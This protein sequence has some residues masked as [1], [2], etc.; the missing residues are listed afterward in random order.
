MHPLLSCPLPGRLALILAVA[1][2]LPLHPDVGAA[3]TA[4][5]PAAQTKAPPKPAAPQAKP[6]ARAPQAK[7]PAKP[8]APAVAA[9]P[10]PPAPPTP[11]DLRYKTTYTTGGLKTESVTFMK[12]ERERFEFADMVLIKQRDQKRTLQI[13]RAANTYLVVPDGA[14]AVAVPNVPA[15]DNAPAKAAGVVMVTTTVMDTGERKQAFGREAR[16][17]KTTMDKQPMVGACDQTKQHMETD[18]WYIDVPVSQTSSGSQAVTPPVLGG[19][20]DEIKATQTG[21]PKALGFPINYTMT[22]NGD[23]GK[24]NI[25]SM[26]ITELET[27]TLDVALFDIPAGFTAAGDLR[28]LS[29]ALSDAS[30]AKLAVAVPP[31]TAAPRT[32]GA[33]RVGVPELTNSSGQEVDTRALRAHLI[34]DLVAAKIEAEPLVAG[35]QAELLQRATER[36]YDYVLVADVTE[37]KV[38]KGG[39]IGGALRAASRAAAAA[40]GPAGPPKDP[41]EATVALKLLQPDGKARLSTTK[42]GKDGGGIDMKTGIGLAKMAGSMYVGM[43][44]GRTMFSALNSMTSGNLSGMGMLGN[45][46]LMN[47][48]TRGL[49]IGGIGG[50]GRGV[51][52]TA[53]AASFLMQQAMASDMPAAGGTAAPS[54]DASLSEALGD[55]AKDV[56]ESVKKADATKKK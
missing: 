13:S 41:T 55:V 33:I 1:F 2:V 38:T 25:V 30:E 14:P 8:A 28:A 44:T 51:D 23:D 42:K 46:A 32:P 34:A 15:P 52:P 17:V 49:G 11:Q 27:T 5:K 53:G 50:I 18:G 31:S 22:V 21:D 56:A 36:G 12:G 54:F 3:Q 45:P 7:A 47:V 40:T 29:K 10:A 19:C 9:A 26:D 16:H 6:P 37:L 24:P 43:L 20:N 39:G 35:S 4:A 48:Q